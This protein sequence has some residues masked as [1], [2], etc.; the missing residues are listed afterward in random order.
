MTRNIQLVNNEIYHIYNRG[1]DGR[2][3]FLDQQDFE[4]FYDSLYLFNDAN[5]D[6]RGQGLIGRFTEI[7][8]MKITGVD[9]RT[10]L[11]D[12]ICFNLMDNHFHLV[13]CQLQEGGIS[14]FMHAVQMGY[15]RVF[16]ERHHRYGSL[17]NRPFQSIHVHQS[18]HFDFLPIYVHLNTLDKYAIPWRTGSVTDWHDALEKL[19]QHHFSSH[20]IAMGRSQELPVVTTDYLR[21]AYPDQESYIAHLKMWSTRY[22]I[23][24]TEFMQRYGDDVNR[25]PY[26]GTVT[27]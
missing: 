23:D 16:N 9:Q 11:V 4:R 20:S 24:Y 21:E 18:G 26:T 14:Q 10:R 15:A 1:V 19:D 6:E 27:S 17:F 8:T 25:N 13:L 5:F 12:I 7:H 2:K 3:I 22:M